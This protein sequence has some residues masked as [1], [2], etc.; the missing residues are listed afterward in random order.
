MCRHEMTPD[1]FTAGPDVM[2]GHSC[3]EQVGFSP[4][5]LVKMHEKRGQFLQ[6][7]LKIAEKEGKTCA[8]CS[9][10]VKSFEVDFEAENRPQID[11][12]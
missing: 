10:S 4:S 9:R 3:V 6:I 1:S 7:L 2:T 11:L 5:F 12:K 8:G